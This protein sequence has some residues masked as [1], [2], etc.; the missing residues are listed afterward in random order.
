MMTIVLP[1]WFLNKFILGIIKKL[2]LLINGFQNGSTGTIYIPTNQELHIC[3]EDILVEGMPNV[4][5]KN[6]DTKTVNYFSNIEIKRLTAKEDDP[7]DEYYKIFR[8][9]DIQKYRIVSVDDNRKGNLQH[10]K[11]GVSE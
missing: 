8:D 10:Y 4:S 6:V 11:L 3:N 2:M 5:V 1:E 7:N 9:N